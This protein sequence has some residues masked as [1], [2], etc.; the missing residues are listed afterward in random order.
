MMPGSNQKSARSA[1]RKDTGV[2]EQYVRSRRQSQ[3]NRNFILV[4]EIREEGFLI[5]WG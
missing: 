1:R 5:K 2:Y 3:E 4:L